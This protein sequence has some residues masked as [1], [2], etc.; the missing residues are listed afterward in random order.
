MSKTGVS[1]PG[2][3]RRAVEDEV[4]MGPAS[5]AE[6]V[7]V[8]SEWNGKPQEDFMERCSVTQSML[9]QDLSSPHV[10]NGLWEI[11]DRSREL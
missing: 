10:G 4:R 3:R 11:W 2:E 8:Y 7:G 6:D 9:S 1:E 5:Q